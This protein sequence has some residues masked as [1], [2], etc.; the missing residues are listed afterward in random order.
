MKKTLLIAA[1]ASLSGCAGAVAYS[2]RGVAN[3]F[4][5]A[6]S[7][8]GEQVSEN[9]VGTAKTGEACAS[10]ILGLVTTGDTSYVTAARNGNIRCA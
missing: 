1:L 9:G 6:D 2:S 3:G 10:S 8:A 5:Y 4:L 7:K